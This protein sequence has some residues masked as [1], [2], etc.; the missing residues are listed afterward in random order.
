MTMNVMKINMAALVYLLLVTLLPA[1]ATETTIAQWTFESTAPTTAGPLSPE[2]GSGT[3][4]AFHSASATYSNPKGNGS[5]ESWG[6]NEWTTG[7]YWEFSVSTIGFDGIRLSFDQ[8]GSAKGPRDFNLEYGMDSTG[9][10]TTISS[11]AL[12]AS[13]SWDSNCFDLTSIGSLD[14]NTTIF[15][16]LVDVDATSIRGGTVGTRGTDRIDNFIVKGTRISNKVPSSTPGMAGLACILGLL[17]VWR[18]TCA[19]D[20]ER[21]RCM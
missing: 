16:R 19:S 6:A 1:L 2:I 12:S 7:D 20:P 8:Y 13:S 18:T 14:N 15:F 17:A 5:N 4:T 21:R 3:G 10:F 9:P 11:Y